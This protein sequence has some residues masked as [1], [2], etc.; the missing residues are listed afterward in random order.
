MGSTQA[1]KRYYHSKK[2][3]GVVEEFR[4]LPDAQRT[5][6]VLRSMAKAAGVREEVIARELEV[7]EALF[8]HLARG[9]K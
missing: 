1:N 4:R 8:G 6:Q 7:A 5:P 9:A 3:D 2:Y